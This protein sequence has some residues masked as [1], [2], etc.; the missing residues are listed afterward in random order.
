MRPGYDDAVGGFGSGMGR[1]MRVERLFA[2]RGGRCFVLT[3]DSFA[4]YGTGPKPV[5]LAAVVDEAGGRGLTGIMG[6]PGSLE[7]T[8]SG[9]ELTRIAALAAS[10]S[11]A[12]DALDKVQIATVEDALRA[13]ADWVAFQF[14]LGAPTESLMLERF[15]RVV[16]ASHCLGL[17][18]LAVAYP[19]TAAGEVSCAHGTAAFRD[20]GYCPHTHAARVAADLGADAIKVRLPEKPACVADTV[21]S[22]APIPV[23]VAGGPVR[24]IHTW[25]SAL[26]SAVSQGARGVC[27]GRNLTHRRDWPSA[28]EVVSAVLEAQD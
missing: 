26:E 25:R 22:C 11:V 21:A 27:V 17:P 23:I 10:T 5:D 3:T 18:V 14:H 13:G 28:V 9:A 24:E 15:G 1:T 4:I 12:P 2:L 6:F 16:S 8:R 19:R 20:S 7:R